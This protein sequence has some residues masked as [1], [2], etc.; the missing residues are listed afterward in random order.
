MV[1]LQKQVQIQSQEAP[2]QIQRIGSIDKNL[3][4]LGGPESFLYTWRGWQLPNQASKPQE[5][6]R[7][8]RIHRQELKFSKL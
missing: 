3:K 2:L 4:A 8:F 7:R 5:D 1:F 6:I